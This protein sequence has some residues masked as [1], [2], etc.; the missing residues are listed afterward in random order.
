MHE[1]RGDG[2]IDTTRQRADD[3]AFADLGAD[4][5]G[6]L[7]NERPGRPRR[8]AV[9][10]SEQEIAQDL[11]AARRVDDL[12]VELDAEDSFAVGERRDRGVAARREEPETGRHLAHVVAVAHPDRQLA[13]QA[14]K[15][16]VGFLHRQERRPVLAGSAG[17]HLA[18]QVMR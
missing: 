1:S 4:A 14:P 6:S 8:L 15:D 12:G 2:R 18:A 16:A 11:P 13:L 5:L 9:A 17:V 7:G 3:P 10:N